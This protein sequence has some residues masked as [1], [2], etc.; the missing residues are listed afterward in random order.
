MANRKTHDI[1]ATVGKYKVGDEEKKRFANCG[2]VFTDDQGRMSLK[3]DSIPVTPEWSGWLSLYPVEG[4]EERQQRPQ[5]QSR[6]PQTRSSRP[7]PPP[8]EAEDDDIPF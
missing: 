2:S 1:V 3:I 4:R 8:L 7:A 6:P 5:T